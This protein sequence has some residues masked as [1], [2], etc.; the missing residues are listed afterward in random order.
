[1][2]AYIGQRI[3]VLLPVVLLVCSAVFAIMHVL[4]GDPVQLM[5]AGA[6]AGVTT[7]ERIA[8]LRKS[9]GLDQPLY[10]QY[11]RFIV[12]AAAGDLGES[13]RF[14]APVNELVSTAAVQTFALSLAGMVAALGIGIPLGIAAGLS[15]NTWLDSGAMFVALL[16]VSMPLFW[17]ALLLILFVAIHLQ[18][19]PAISGGQPKG[20]IL[21]AFTLGFVSAGIISRLMRAS[22]IEALRHD[23]VRTA[24]AK[25]LPYRAVA[26]KHALRNALIPVITVAGLQF[27]GMLSG[28]VITETVFSRPG[29]G[30]LIVKAILWHDY[31]LIQ[32]AVLLTSA[33]YVT[34][35]LLIDVL[36]AWVDPR[37]RYA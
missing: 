8:Q 3:A 21:P 14:Q 1:V 30:S 15:E 33:S 31:P 9:M 32:G 28:A 18:W 7:P 35:N 29:L 11:S 37:I 26:V 6:E 12:H 34:V 17:L 25:G 19:L 23:Y 16:G 10:A 36:Y 20:I 27:G 5:L 13:I 4:P 22:L 24:M 2:S